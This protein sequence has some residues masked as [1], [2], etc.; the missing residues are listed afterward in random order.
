MEPCLDLGLPE[1]ALDGRL[2]ARLRRR[3]KDRDHP[4]T[5]AGPRHAADGVGMN[6]CPFKDGI[7]VKL[8]VARETDR[9]P[10]FDHGFHG[11]VRGDDRLRPRHDHASVERNAIEDL[12]RRASLDD[13]AFDDVEAIQLRTAIGHPRHVP[14]ARGGGRRT[15]RW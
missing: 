14:A 4:Q 11:E 6:L 8:G 2:K 15:R 13:Q 7:V 10:V 12:D 3:H 9:P 1:P 5:Q